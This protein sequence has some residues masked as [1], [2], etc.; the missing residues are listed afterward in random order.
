MRPSVAQEDTGRMCFRLPGEPRDERP[1]LRIEEFWDSAEEGSAYLSAVRNNPRIADLEAETV[2]SPLAYIQRIAEIVAKQNLP[3]PAK[4]IP[5][6]HR[7]N[8]E[9]TGPREPI[10]EN[11]LSFEDRTDAIY[12]RQPGEEG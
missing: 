1:S 11:G 10:Q 3:K 6:R 5:P 4:R 8:R 12:E 2:E 7:P 9:Y